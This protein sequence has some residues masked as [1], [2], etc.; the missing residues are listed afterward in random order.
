VAFFRFVV[1]AAMQKMGK[2]SFTLLA[3]IFSK[4]NT[5]RIRRTQLKEISGRRAGRGRVNSRHFVQYQETDI[6][7]HAAHRQPDK[8]TSSELDKGLFI[9][10]DPVPI[11]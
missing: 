11:R 9:T 4:V 10:C 3:V 2:C 6:A 8:R 7:E 5:V 1:A